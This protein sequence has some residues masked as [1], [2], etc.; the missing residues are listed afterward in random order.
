[1][2]SFVSFHRRRHTQM[3]YVKYQERLAEEQTIAA[4]KEESMRSHVETLTA[5]TR[6]VEHV[7]EDVSEQRLD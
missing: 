5:R 2:V 1:M 4:K 7:I 3:E 6:N